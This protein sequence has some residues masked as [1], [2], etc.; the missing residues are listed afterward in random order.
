MNN[1]LPVLPDW[2][3]IALITII[4]AIGVLIC[5]MSA[6]NDIKEARRERIRRE[7]KIRVEEAKK[8][9]ELAAFYTAVAYGDE[10]DF[11]YW[12]DTAQKFK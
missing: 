12:Y 6:V 5:I 10:R 3:G 9:N 7:L 11:S 1:N 4:G 2:F 8:S